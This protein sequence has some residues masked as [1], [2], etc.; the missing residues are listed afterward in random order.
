[1]AEYNI[2]MRQKNSQGEYDT[3][4]PATTGEQVSGI[5]TAEET[6]TSTTAQS[7]GLSASATPDEV[8]QIISQ[9]CWRLIASYKTAGSF[10]FTVPDGVTEI[11]VYMVGGGGSGAS[12]G[13]TSSQAFVA[14]GGAAGYGGNF[15]FQVTPGQIISGIVGAGGG[16]VS[17]MN[18][19]KTGGSTSFNNITVSGGSGGSFNLASSPVRG[20]TG[21]QGSD[22]SGNSGGDVYNARKIYAGTQ[23]YQN[24]GVVGGFSQT[25]RESQNAFD[26]TMVTLCAGGWAKG[27]ETNDVETILPMPDGTKGGSGKNG[28]RVVVY[29]ENAT[30]NGNGGGASYNYNDTGYYACYSGAGSPGMVLIYTRGGSTT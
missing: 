20:G 11:G 16:S 3:L 5:Y 9:Y 22:A 1:M 29:G 6:L 18:N 25:P 26:T 8:F 23:T 13:L 2:T 12:G 24:N 19:G 10:Q 17:Q 4:Y 7:F 14:T 21:G 27:I 30:G 15:I 28:F